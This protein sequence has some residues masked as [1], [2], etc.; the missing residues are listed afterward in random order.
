M[1]ERS[2]VL[3]NVV[4]KRCP[5]QQL[6]VEGST[7]PLA[8]QKLQC[9]SEHGI[10]GGF[11]GQGHVQTAMTETALQFQVREECRFGLAF[12]HRSFHKENARR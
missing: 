2:Q 9:S 11:G 6:Q 4:K 12:P 7:W 1:P 10:S 5:M 3:K 8:A